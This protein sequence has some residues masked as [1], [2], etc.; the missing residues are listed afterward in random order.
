VPGQ[1]NPAPLHDRLLVTGH[2]LEWLAL[3]PEE[4]QPPR[5]TVI[6]A[7]QWLARTLVEMDQK[8][9]VDSY[10]PYTHAARAL[11]LWRSVEPAAAWKKGAAA[12]HSQ[13]SQ[14]TSDK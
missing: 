13:V 7:A 1:E 4:V 14:L 11:C 2:Q 9:L 3:A 6:R 10:G 5:Q 12:P 8:E